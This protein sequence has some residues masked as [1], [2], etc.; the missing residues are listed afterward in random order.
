MAYAA[1]AVSRLALS[2]L[3]TTTSLQRQSARRGF[4][5]WIQ[6]KPAP[7]KERAVCGKWTGG[8]LAPSTQL[9][10]PAP[11]SIIMSASA[12]VANAQASAAAEIED[13]A[14]TVSCEW[15][16]SKLG[17]VKVLD[18]S[19]YMPAEQ[20]KPEEEF[21]ACHIPG[22]LFFDIDKVSRTD[23]DLPHMLPS[24]AVFSRALSDLGIGRHDR[25]VVY[26]G[27]GIF[28]APRAW[29]MFRA[30]GHERVH[31]LEG[32]LPRWKALGFQTDSG[33][34]ET[35]RTQE[36]G[37]PL[38]LNESLLREAE[39]VQRN[40]ETR[41]A[42]VVDA[43]GAGR[44]HG[45]EPEPRKGVRGGHIPGS[46]NV[47]FPQVLTSDGRMKPVEELRTVFASAGVS[48][49][50]PIITSCGTGVTA[51]VLALALHKL[52]KKDA[53]IY[54]GSWTE[55]GGRKDLPLEME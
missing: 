37:E 25:V 5:F 39:D 32:G 31:V 54:D 36:P 15:L 7:S 10:T 48:L 9:K 52:G 55:W 40:L 3:P 41:E 47:P 29:W 43:R 1:C 18:A 33:R 34:P 4:A 23:T 11:R 17:N 6:C 42:D 13:D 16:Q 49:D 35:S 44:F 12:N 24:G 21:L 26:D 27:K 8:G 19:W 28:S 38:E 50:R 14:A 45:T 51:C 20:R 46:K 22:A 30:F 2:L 53:A